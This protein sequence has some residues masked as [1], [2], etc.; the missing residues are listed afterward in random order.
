MPKSTAPL[1]TFT[2]LTNLD[3]EDVEFTHRTRLT[4]DMSDP[5]NL[6]ILR[7]EALTAYARLKKAGKA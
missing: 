5:F 1:R 7:T 2:I 6:A 3:G 4:G